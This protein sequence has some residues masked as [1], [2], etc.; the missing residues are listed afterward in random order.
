M[1]APHNSNQ[2]LDSPTFHLTPFY[3]NSPPPSCWQA[4]PSSK[5]CNCGCL[6]GNF[7]GSSPCSH[8]WRGAVW[9]WS[10][11][12]NEARQYVVT[13]TEAFQNV[14]NVLACCCFDW[15]PGMGVSAL[16]EWLGND[17]DV[18]GVVESLP[19]HG[20][21][22][23]GQATWWEGG[24]WS[25]PALQLAQ[26]AGDRW[27]GMPCAMSSRCSPSQLSNRARACKNSRTGP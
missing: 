16:W 11:L 2:V 8:F 6:G 26:Y 20:H 7:E 15:Q 22:G 27:K 13:K 18:F 19:R 14:Y 10:S 9:V 25:W 5:G 4:Q 21:E 24:C 12:R 1:K 3:E 23:V 17:V